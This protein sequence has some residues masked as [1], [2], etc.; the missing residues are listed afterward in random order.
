MITITTYKKISD[1][2]NDAQARGIDIVYYID[3]MAVDL[4]LSD[5]PSQDANRL[6]LESQITTTS[7]L[8]TNTDLL[9]TKQ[10]K[11]FVGALQRD[12]DDGYSSVND[13]L[14]DNDTKVGS[15]FASISAVVGF[16]ID[17]SNIEGYEEPSA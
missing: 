3:K 2:I 12:V 14:S 4:A 1:F 16:I 5:I 9:Y 10:M 15:T 6:R 8:L 11:I 7:N 13:F 17:P